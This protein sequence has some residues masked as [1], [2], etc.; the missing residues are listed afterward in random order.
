MLLSL[1]HTHMHTTHTEKH[2][3]DTLHLYIHTYRTAGGN[4][5]IF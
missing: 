2:D 3:A 5:S 4:G 1:S